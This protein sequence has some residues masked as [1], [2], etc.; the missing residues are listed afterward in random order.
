MRPTRT[1]TGP[2]SPAG[3]I[4]CVICPNPIPLDEYRTARCWTDPQ[5]V[6]CAAHAHCLVWVGE[7]DLDLPPAA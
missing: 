3:Y 2:A 7:Q 6:T 1:G 4:P 5:G